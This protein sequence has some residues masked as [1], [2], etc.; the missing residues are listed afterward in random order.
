LCQLGQIR[1]GIGVRLYFTT[2]IY[3]IVIFSAAFLMYSLYAMITNLNASSIYRFYLEAEIENLALVCAQSGECSTANIGLGSK[4]ANYD[5]FKNEIAVQTVLGFMFVIV[6]GSI[7]IQKYR[8]DKQ[9]E[10]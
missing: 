2:L 4:L 8:S 1:L 9:L 6:W 3:F 10:T 7:I 5:E